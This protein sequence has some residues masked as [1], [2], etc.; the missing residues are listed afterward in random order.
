MLLCTRNDLPLDLLACA[1][2][3]QYTIDFGGTMPFTVLPCSRC[4][5][6]KGQRSNF[7][8]VQL[9]SYTD[10]ELFLRSEA[11]PSSSLYQMIGRTLI[12]QEKYHD[13]GL[14]L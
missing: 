8:F 2:V 4:F 5:M 1:H 11:A 10:Y 14:V 6:V 9:V 12:I 7:N 3:F 13:H